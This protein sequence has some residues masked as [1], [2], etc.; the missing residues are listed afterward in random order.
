MRLIHR[1]LHQWYGITPAAVLNPGPASANATDAL[2]HAAD[3]YRLVHNLQA[4]AI[5]I[6][7]GSVNYARWR[8]SSTYIRY[9]QCARQ[10]RGL[11]LTLLTG[12]EVQLAFWI[13]VYNALMIDAVIQFGVG[14]SIREVRGFFWRAAYSIGGQRFNAYDIEFGILRANAPH[15]T[16]PGPHFAADDARLKFSLP[17]RDPRIHFALNCAS[18]SCPAINFYRS[19][20]IDRQLELAT[21]AFINGGGVKINRAAGEVILSKIFQWYAP[22][23]GAGW[24]ALDHQRP[25]LEFVASYVANENDRAYLQHGRPKVKFQRYDWLLNRVAV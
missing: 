20:Q 7:R 19:D 5:D 22:D 24:L 10:L 17:Q 13:N 6:E 15:P 11:D 12:R 8:E 2:D 3:L 14:R 18:R 21:R 16:I 9:Q 25:L 4:E 1:L 23:F